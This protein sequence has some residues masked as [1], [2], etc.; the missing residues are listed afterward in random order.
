MVRCKIYIFQTRLICIEYLKLSIIICRD[1]FSN[2]IYQIK[3]IGGYLFRVIIIITIVF[4]C[5]CVV[6]TYCVRLKL[7]EKKNN[8]TYL[9]LS[10]V[11]CKFKLLSK[12]TSITTMKVGQFFFKDLDNSFQW[13]S[14]K[15]LMLNKHLINI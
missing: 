4:S 11:Y 7:F 6:I 12:I 8:Y 13:F 2:L 1:N 5:F 10:I 3:K 9:Y 15:F 14:T